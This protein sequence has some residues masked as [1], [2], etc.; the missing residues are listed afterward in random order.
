MML[1]LRNEALSLTSKNAGNQLSEAQLETAKTISA[2]Q[3]NG[4]NGSTYRDINNG[5]HIQSTL[6]ATNSL[7]HLKQDL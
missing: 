2:I 1:K 4:N 5:E 6:Y 3:A 7:K